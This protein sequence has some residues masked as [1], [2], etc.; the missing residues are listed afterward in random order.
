ME[1]CDSLPT[2]WESRRGGKT[3]GLELQDELRFQ[4]LVHPSTCYV[5]FILYS[6]DLVS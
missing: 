3:T 6:A 2:K 1:H 4:P 5:G